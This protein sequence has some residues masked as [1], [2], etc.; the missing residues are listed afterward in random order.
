MCCYCPILFT[1]LAVDHNILDAGIKL[2]KFR[3]VGRSF[4]Q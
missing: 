3:V 2:S 4:T 1:Y